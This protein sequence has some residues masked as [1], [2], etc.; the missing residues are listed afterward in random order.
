ME[1]LTSRLPIVD[2][3]EAL[4]ALTKQI[5]FKRIEAVDE[6]VEQQASA[7]LN[8]I[9]LI[10]AEKKNTCSRLLSSPAPLHH[11]ELARA[12]GLLPREGTQVSA[13]STSSTRVCPASCST[14]RSASGSTRRTTH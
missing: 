1:S 7:S 10:N 4:K 5:Y 2:N 12:A 14:R 3:D 13:S 9:G 11:A 6:L 8:F